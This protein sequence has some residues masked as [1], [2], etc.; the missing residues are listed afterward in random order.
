MNQPNQ[1][2][3]PD[4]TDSGVHGRLAVGTVT[5]VALVRQI[6][7]VT[8]RTTLLAW[9]M[10]I[11]CVLGVTLAPFIG[12]VSLLVKALLTA[13]AGALAVI[14]VHRW[15]P[16]PRMAD[17]LPFW[18][19]EVSGAEHECLARGKL[20]K[21]PP[22]QGSS[23]DVYGKRSPTGVIMVRRLVNPNGEVSRPRLPFGVVAHVAATW[24]VIGLQA[25]T[26]VFLAWLLAFS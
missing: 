7:V 19:K 6:D 20:P 11:P 12:G 4:L 16:Q 8:R 13:C 9:L 23:V 26:V 17:E 15:G 22:Q 1:S 14:V 3:T 10:A 24:L 21:G 2:S 25:A 18:V 5:R